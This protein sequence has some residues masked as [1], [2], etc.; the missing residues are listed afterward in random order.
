MELAIQLTT[1]DKIKREKKTI[2]RKS[3]L[4]EK[5]ELR[6]NNKE[7]YDKKRANC[8]I[9]VM[10]RHISKSQKT[11]S[12]RCCDRLSRSEYSNIFYAEY[13]LL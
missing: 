10:E 8:P 1:N 5:K 12:Y 4:E 6:R 9:V 3:M 7:T 11:L 13:K 2:K